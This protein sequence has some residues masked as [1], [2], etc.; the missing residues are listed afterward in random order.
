MCWEIY[1][2]QPIMKVIG[3]KKTFKT[4]NSSEVLYGLHISNASTMGGGKCDERFGR[5][6]HSNS[7]HSQ[8]CWIQSCLARGPV[9]TALLREGGSLHSV[10]HDWIYYQREEC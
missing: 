5:K 8:L 1:F 9:F 3:K 6:L 7:C 2:A 10:N 4:N